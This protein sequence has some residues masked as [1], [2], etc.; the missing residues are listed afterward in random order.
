MLKQ[1]L[2]TAI[3]LIPLVVAGILYLPKTAIAIIFAVILLQGAWEWSALAGISNNIFRFIYVLIIGL[4][5]YYFW[6]GTGDRFLMQA[7]GFFAA[8]WWFI[9]FL[10]ILFP[11]LLKQ[12][13]ILGIIVKLA[14]GGFVLVPVWF[15]LVSIHSVSDNGPV[16]LLYAMVLVWVADSGAYFAGKSFGKHKLAPKVSPGKTWEGVFGAVILVILY[17]LVAPL[18]LPIEDDLIKWLVIISAA[19]VPL[20]VIGDLFESLMKRHSG[21]KDSGKLLPGH[22]GVLDRIDGL[23]PSIPVFMLVSLMTGLL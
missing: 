1:R 8:I 12:K 15:A 4:G 13:S 16:W 7:N 22:G 23:T 19:L 5:L 14:S 9:A 2:L 17:S 10:W 18:W 20:S 6:P 21:I 3:I 11:Q